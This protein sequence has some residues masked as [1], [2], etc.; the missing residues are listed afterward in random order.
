MDLRQAEYLKLMGIQAWCK[1]EDL[2]I[3]QENARLLKQGLVA[4]QM[5]SSGALM[6]QNPQAQNSAI[7]SMP[8]R[9]ES[10]ASLTG[11]VNLDERRGDNQQ[12]SITAKGSLDSYNPSIPA[13]SKRFTQQLE[14]VTTGIRV[15]VNP[16]ATESIAVKRRYTPIPFTYPIDASIFAPQ[17]KVAIESC[18]A[19]DFSQTRHKATLPR[20]HEGAR[21]MVITDI[22]LKEEMFSGQV[23]DR[24]DESFFYKAMSAVGFMPEDLYITPFIKC[25][26]PELRDVD[27]AEWHACFQVLKREIT[28]VNPKAILLLGRN[29]VKF[30][31]EKELPFEELRREKHLI[32][33]EG[34]EYPVVVSHSPRVY[35]RNARLKSNFWQDLK[36]FRRLVD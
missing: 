34:N 1:Q 12:A 22:P 2:P 25:R 30:M 23:L 16:K 7:S 6:G 28:E 17:F 26:P 13:E 15:D 14:D 33:I 27:A 19:C 18:E 24:S 32:Q 21:L 36:F 29:S 8:R 31:L 9:T 35:A 10:L 11:G 20:Q 4:N 5:Q 3:A